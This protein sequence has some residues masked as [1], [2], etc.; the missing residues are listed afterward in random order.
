MEQ[1]NFLQTFQNCTHRWAILT[2]CIPH[3]LIKLGQSFHL[4]DTNSSTSTKPT[5]RKKKPFLN[6]GNKAVK[7]DNILLSGYH[8]T[9]HWWTYF[10][11]WWLLFEWT[12]ISSCFPRKAQLQFGI[13][14]EKVYIWQNEKESQIHSFLLRDERAEKPSEWQPNLSTCLFF[15]EATFHGATLCSSFLMQENLHIFTFVTVC[16]CICACRHE[17]HHLNLHGN[18]IPVS[19]TP[20][21]IRD[22]GR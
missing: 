7:P 3:S 20:A 9:W 5:M 10:Q 4:Q 14:Q 13:T 19:Q 15:W 11:P 18:D 22:S 8:C 17:R 21:R 12:F 1:H 16:D 6:M 2:I